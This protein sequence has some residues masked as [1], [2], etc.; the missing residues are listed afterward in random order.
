LREKTGTPGSRPLAPGLSC[1]ATQLV[2]DLSLPTSRS[3]VSRDNR[4]FPD[5][6]LASIFHNIRMRWPTHLSHARANTVSVILRCDPRFDR[7]EPR[8]TT[9]L[10]SAA[11]FEGRLRGH[12]RMTE[13][14]SSNRVLAAR[15][16]ARVLSSRGC[17]FRA[18]RSMKWCAAEPGPCHT[19]SLERSRICGAPNS[20]FTRVD[21]LLRDAPRPGKEQARNTNK[22]E[23]RRSAERRIH[24]RARRS[25]AGRR[26]VRLPLRKRGLHTQP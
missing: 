4:R 8:R 1:N 13:R 19:Q 16:C 23:G 6:H 25:T 21:A 24:G 15:L 18:Q 14:R 7:G 5:A 22:S 9:A 2:C 20:A 10:A 26:F 17:V 12:L 3:A 11:S